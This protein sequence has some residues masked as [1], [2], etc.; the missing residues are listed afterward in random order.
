[1]HHGIDFNSRVARARAFYRAMLLDVQLGMRSQSDAEASAVRAVLKDG[2]DYDW[3][4]C[5]AAILAP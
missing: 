5:L 2:D 4:A 3:D 1:M